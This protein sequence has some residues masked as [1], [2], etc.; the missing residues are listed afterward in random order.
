MNGWWSLLPRS[1]G[2][3]SVLLLIVLGSVRA[4]AVSPAE[5]FEAGNA[6]L[7]KGQAAEALAAYG[8]IGP[9]TTS[10][11]LEFNRG[12]A[13]AQLGHLGEALV[14]VRRAERLAPRDRDIRVALKQ[15]RARV[16][17]PTRPAAVLEGNL[18]LLPLNG[19]ALIAAASCWTWFA[20]LIVRRAGPTIRET[21]RG[22]TLAAGIAAGAGA[23]ALG[24]AWWSRMEEPAIVVT[25]ANA[26]VRISPLAEAKVAFTA[27]DGAELRLSEERAGWFRVQ[28][29]ISGRSGWLNA[30]SAARVPLH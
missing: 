2:R 23:T 18:G 12:L 29:P 25:Q 9:D 13:H 11:A 28:E 7:A 4:F 8:Q 6:F 19:W 30:T 16:S 21:V 17:G 26:A 27:I 5:H 22:Y 20:L 3:G 10:A 1:V 15:V 14:R 24:L